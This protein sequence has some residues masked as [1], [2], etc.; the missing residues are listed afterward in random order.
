M[1]RA[2]ID[3]TYPKVPAVDV[4]ANDDGYI[5]SGAKVN[6]I[7]EYINEIEIDLKEEL[8]TETHEVTLNIDIENIG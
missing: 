5:T 7:Y 1:T 4:E 6:K 3:A 8:K 2:P